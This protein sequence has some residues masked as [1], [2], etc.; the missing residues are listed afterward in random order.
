MAQSPYEIP[1]EMRD[2]A[3]KS[4]EQ[5]RKAFEGFIGAAQ[6]AVSAAEATPF[7]VPGVKEVGAKAVAYAE[8]N[9]KAA[10]DHAQKLV[11]AKD[12]QEVL[13]LQNE[14]LKAQLTTL[15]DQAKEFGAAVQKA[16]TPKSS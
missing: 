13:R 8:A 9:V 15:Q 3:E 4:V 10:F 1:A 16:V 12:V 5:A 7:A 6:K 2:F 11:N 14:Y